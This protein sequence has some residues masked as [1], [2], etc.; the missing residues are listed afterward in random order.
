MED[1]TQHPN[2]S[3]TKPTGKCL[4]FSAPSGAGK[5][6]LVHHLLSQ[7]TSFKFS[8]SACSRPARGEEKNGVDYHFLSIEDF[9]SKIDEGAFIE[10]EE[11]YEG[12]FYGTLKSEVERI[13]AAGNVAVFDVDVEGGI[14]LKN[15]FGNQALALFIQPPSIEELEN[16]LRQRGTE[17]EESLQTRLRKAQHELSR[18]DLFDIVLVNDNLSDAKVEITRLCKKF[19][20][21]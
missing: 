11:V 9:K 3:T 6:T 14:K 12:H 13:W 2:T 16:R 10:W 21:E 18:S 15:Y 17:N 8:V 20:A 4:I 5:T 19:L 7:N 1:Q